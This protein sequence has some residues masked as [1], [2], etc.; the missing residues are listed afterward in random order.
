MANT[1]RGTTVAEIEKKKGERRDRIEEGEKKSQTIIPRRTDEEQDPSSSGTVP[2]SGE[3][4]DEGSIEESGGI[5]G[6]GN[7]R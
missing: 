1:T 2:L 3:S 5:E 6:P 4:S 7:T